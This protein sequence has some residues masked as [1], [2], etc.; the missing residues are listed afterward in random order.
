ML[1][2]RQDLNLNYEKSMFSAFT[3]YQF[4][5]SLL[6]DYIATAYEIIKIKV[7]CSNVM[8][9]EYSEKDIERFG[10]DRLNSTFR[11]LCHNK[12]LSKAIK[13]ISQ[14]RNELAHEAFFNKFK[15]QLSEVSDEQLFEKTCKF[16]ECRSKLEPII[17][18]LLREL[19][20]IQAEL[21]ALSG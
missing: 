20:F 15:E 17:T 12:D 4:I 11:K 6:R 14:T 21:K 5:E 8:N 1:A 19:R 10:L 2:N 7:S 16:L 9:F 18:K 3:N 13:D